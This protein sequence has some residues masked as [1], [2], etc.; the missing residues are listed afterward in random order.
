MSFLKKL[1]GGESSG[2]GAPKP[3]AELTYEGF[4]ILSTPI[5]EGGQYRVCAVIR[6]EI[7]GEVKEHKLVRADVCSTVDDASDISVRK[8]KQMI[9]ERGEGVFG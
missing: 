4:Q 3:V 1:F 7:E 9:D 6:K 8:A 2:G 5:G